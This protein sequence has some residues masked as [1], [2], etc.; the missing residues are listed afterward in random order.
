[1]Q[2]SFAENYSQSTVGI[3]AYQSLRGS[4]APLH[5]GIYWIQIP[6]GTIE[7]YTYKGSGP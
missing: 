4:Y 6:H 2:M 5:T 7:I 3:T 1:M